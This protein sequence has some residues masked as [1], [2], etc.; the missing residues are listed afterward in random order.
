MMLMIPGT[1]AFVVLVLAVGLVVGLWI[2]LATYFV[3]KMLR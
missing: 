1:W 3:I 2:V